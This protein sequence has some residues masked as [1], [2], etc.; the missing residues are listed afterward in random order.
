MKTKTFKQ[1]IDRMIEKGA[2]SIKITR[3]TSFCGCIKPN[4]IISIEIIKDVNI[5]VASAT[6]VF[7]E[8]K[9]DIDKL[10]RDESGRCIARWT[11]GRFNYAI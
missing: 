11:I 5:Y 4:D 9:I 7:D 6:H 1:I 10:V 3:S 2:D 8:P